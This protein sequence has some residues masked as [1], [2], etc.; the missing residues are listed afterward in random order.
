M[1]KKKKEKGCFTLPPGLH[2]RGEKDVGGED[3]VSRVGG[4]GEGGNVLW[5]A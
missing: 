1:R 3:S 4:C 2:H 5:G